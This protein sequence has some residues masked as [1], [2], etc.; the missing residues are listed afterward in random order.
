[1]T[2]VLQG[3]RHLRPRG[4][5]SVAD[6]QHVVKVAARSVNETAACGLD[7]FAVLERYVGDLEI[8]D[9]HTRSI[10]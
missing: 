6:H 2:V 10:D 8:R 1:V 7:V 5:L 4:Y 9:V 3:T